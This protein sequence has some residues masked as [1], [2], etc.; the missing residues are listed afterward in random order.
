MIEQN[1][2]QPIPIA[3]YGA[4]QRVRLFV[5]GR[6]KLIVGIKSVGIV[7]PQGIFEFIVK[8]TG[9]YQFFMSRHF[10]PTPFLDIC[11]PLYQAIFTIGTII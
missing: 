4:S 2:L 10:V 1:V 8:G 6:Q 11:K 5:S 9:F 7:V 3:V